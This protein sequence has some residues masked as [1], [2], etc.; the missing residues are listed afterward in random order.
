M[1][2]I[3]NKEIIAKVSDALIKAAKV[4]LK[5]CLCGIKCGTW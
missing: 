4:L 3:D 1:R 2:K 5:W